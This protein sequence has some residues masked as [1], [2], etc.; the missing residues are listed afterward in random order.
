MIQKE[1]FKK[2]MDL[3]L[4]SF[5][6]L[7]FEILFIRWIP[8]CIQIVAYFTNIILI[9]AFLGLGLGC[10][11]TDKK[12][13]L[14]G[15]FPALIFNLA[16][17]LTV[18][19]NVNIK[20]SFIEGEHLL[21]F[22]SAQGVNFLFIIV[23]V[24]IFNALIFIPLGQKLG[25]CLKY[26]KPLAAY[27]INIFGSIIGVAVFS[28]L[29][30]LMLPPFYWFLFGLAM[31]LWF[32]IQS[33]KELLFQIL[34]CLSIPLIVLQINSKSYWSPYYKIDIYSFVSNIS[35]KV[36]GFFI[37]AN[38]THHQYAFNLTQESVA[39]TPE[40][41][42]YKEIYEFPYKLKHPRNSLILGGGCG[43]DASAALRMGVKDIYAI[44][45]DPFIAILGKRL[46][47]ERP[48]LAPNVHLYIDD[49]RAFIRKT[50]RKFDLITFGYLDAHKVLSQFS[51][52][53][54]DNFIYTKE[55]FKDIR[56]HLSAD[57]M[58][59]LTYLVFREWIGSKLYAGLRNV[60]HDDLI[61]FRTQTYNPD[62]TAIFLAGPGVRNIG[63]TDIPGFKI[64]DGF[65]K[66]A[67]FIT[68]DWPYLYLV[69]RAIP[70][71]YIIILLITLII[72]AL[73]IFYVKQEPLA[74]FNTHFFF[75]GAGFMLLETVSI[76][77]F[78]LLFG[79][80][81]IVNSAVIISILVMVLL[82]NLYV[83]RSKKMN[84]QL[85][86]LLLVLS[87]LLNWLLKPDFYFAFNRIIGITL[88]SLILSLP[89]LFAGV[90]FAVSFKGARDI[91]GVFA[92]N[93]L[94]AIIGGF[95]EYISM[96]TGFRFLFIV[97]IVMYGL[98][99]LGLKK[100]SALIRA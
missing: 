33:K 30:Y 18:F 65:D 36:L 54:L 16:A 61:V 10:M 97:A 85:I 42:H 92:Y 35:N 55:S 4:I 70:V 22:Y 37:S 64:Y 88:S 94:G 53:R 2:G 99:Y 95:C 24:F 19:N 57:G 78:A 67:S 89:L 6:A 98:S 44:E 1:G 8:S 29:S 26:F 76:T 68:D 72:S 71:H 45:I 15:F 74:K 43:N 56:D 93:L 27:S 28:F 82:A 81:W 40:L 23:L 11:L 14:I 91:P 12:F 86:Y 69:G 41:L 58:M 7:Y 79:S 50:D 48:Y 52:V 46:H 3:F 87:I 13:N 60:F 100:V 5:I 59:S 38:N 80:T 20:A 39:A 34:I 21:G 90:I 75:L 73:G 9:S 62:D 31:M 32:Y 96:I 66:N 47:E 77:R 63:N 17:F 49:A 51:S 25:S 83:T 84:I